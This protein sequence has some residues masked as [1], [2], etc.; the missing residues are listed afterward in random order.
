MGLDTSDTDISLTPNMVSGSESTLSV[1]FSPLRTSHG[2]VYTCQAGFNIP[3]A[4]LP[5][6][7]NTLT[8][9]VTVQSECVCVCCNGVY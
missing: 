1:T 2:D 8:T 4:N 5:D 3:E 9:T 7:N 6:L